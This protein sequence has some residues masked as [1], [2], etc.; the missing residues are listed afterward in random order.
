M[1]LAVGFRDGTDRACAANDAA[2]PMRPICRSRRGDTSMR[3]GGELAADGI[4]PSVP[5]ARSPAA[6]APPAACPRAPAR[7]IARSPVLWCK[8][9]VETE[10]IDPVSPNEAT[11]PIR[12]ICGRHRGAIFLRVAQRTVGSALAQPQKTY[13]ADP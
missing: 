1:R 10:L 9:G 11:A 12:A 4:D 8:A 3:I 13:V 5:R 2:A 6:W 7:G